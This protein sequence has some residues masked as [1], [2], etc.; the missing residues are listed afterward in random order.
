[1]VEGEY[2][3][4]EE[5]K[6]L[7]KSSNDVH[8][9]FLSRSK[10]FKAAT[11]RLAALASGLQERHTWWRDNDGTLTAISNLEITVRSC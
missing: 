8:H 1:L 7:P 6:E 2:E 9:S 10:A 5:A 11:G 4:V 3:E